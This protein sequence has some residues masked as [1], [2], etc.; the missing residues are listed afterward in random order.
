MRTRVIQSDQDEV[1]TNGHPAT[2]GA[3]QVLDR[4]VETDEVGPAPVVSADDL[5]RQFGTDETAVQALRVS[6]SM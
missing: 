3:A 5:T 1:A 4:P 6:R 2:D